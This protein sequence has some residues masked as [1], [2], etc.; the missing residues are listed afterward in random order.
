MTEIIE[1]SILQNDFI[2]AAD[3]SVSSLS[4]SLVMRDL[5]WFSFSFWR[6]SE[7][8]ISSFFFDVVLAFTFFSTAFFEVAFFLVAVLVAE[9]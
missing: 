2:Y 7:G 9:V 1:S 4:N 6:K 3:F 5:S 8:L